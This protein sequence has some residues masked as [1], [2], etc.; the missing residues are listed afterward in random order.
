L[1]A[2]LQQAGITYVF[3]GKE[4]GARS[5]NPACYRQGRVQYELLAKEPVFQ[6]GMERLREGMQRYRIALVCAEK[7]PLDC[8][9]AVLVARRMRESGVPVQHIHADGRLESHSDMEAR[10]LNLLK[11]SDTDMFRSREE[12]IAEAYQTRGQQIAY[13]D[14][15]ML[16]EELKSRKLA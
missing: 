2:S 13:Q 5:E 16:E 7:D 1:R 11:V 3:L 15:A 8:H 14:D 12:I 6:Q 10:M 9:R 4:L